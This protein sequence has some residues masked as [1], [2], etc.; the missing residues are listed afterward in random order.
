MID[1]VIGIPTLLAL[2]GLI[3]LLKDTYVCSELDR[4]F[5]LNLDQPGKGLPEGVVF[6]NSTPTIPHG[7]ATN[8]RPGPS[9]LHYTFAEDHTLFSSSTS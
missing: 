7:L 8:I 4:V 6:D 5:P 2:G 1:F 3:T 9:L